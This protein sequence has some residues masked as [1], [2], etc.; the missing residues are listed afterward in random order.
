[1]EATAVSK[2]TLYRVFGALMALLVLTGALSYV[3]LGPFNLVLS[4][5]IAAAKAVLIFLF[6]MHIHKSS[7]LTRLFAL[8]GLLWIVIM[9]LLTFGDYLTRTGLR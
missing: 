9:L 6:F 5:G 8:A 7:G 3:S 4:L 1:M 2:G